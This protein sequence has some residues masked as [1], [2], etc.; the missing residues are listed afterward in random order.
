LEDEQRLNNAL[1]GW[2]NLAAV[3]AV[4]FSANVNDFVH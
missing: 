2:P 1:T 4:R 3:R